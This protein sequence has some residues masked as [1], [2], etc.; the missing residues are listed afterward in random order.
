MFFSDKKKL[1]WNEPQ[2]IE[3]LQSLLSTD[4]VVLVFKHSTRCS[5]SSFALKRFESDFDLSAV[6]L[7]YID[8]IANRDLSNFMAS[9]WNIVHQ[10]PQVLIRLQNGSMTSFS[11][12]G[13][14]ADRIQ[15]FITN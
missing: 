13:I 6:K 4:E 3:E 10:S 2:S 8:V 11:H 1:A 9:E 5:I 14:Q 15:Q 12:E 7:I